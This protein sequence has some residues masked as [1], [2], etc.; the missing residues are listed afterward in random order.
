MGLI[1]IGYRGS[2]KTTVGQLLSRWLGLKFIDI[3]QR[4]VQQTGRSIRAIFESEGE[5]AFR[6]LESRAIGEAVGLAD[7][8]IAVGGGAL[9]R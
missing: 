3:D 5:A 4:I 6:V 7:H 2:G 1:L 8:V 9:G